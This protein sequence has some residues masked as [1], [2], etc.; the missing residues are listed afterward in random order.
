LILPKLLCASDRE[1]VQRETKFFE[2][3]LIYWEMLM[4]FVTQDAVTFSQ[5]SVTR[6][7]T[8]PSA[9]GAMA[10]NKDGKIVPHPWTGIAP[11]IQL[12]FAEVGRLVRSERLL[13]LN[14]AIDRRRKYDN[15]LNAATLE[16]D[17]LA[18]ECPR[19]DELADPGD[20]YT[21]KRD[22]IVIAEAYRCTGLLEL[23]RVFPSLLRKRLG[24]DRFTWT[25]QVEF[26]FPTP[27][28]ETPYEDTDTKLWLNSLAVHILKTLESLPSSTGTCCLQPI[29]LLA[30]GA[31]LKFVSSV[32]Y[33]DIYANDAKVL[34]ARGFAANRLQE[35]AMR[36][37][38]K[39]VR[40]SIEILNE[41]WR[42]VDDGQ[43]NV[44]WIDVMVEKGWHTIMG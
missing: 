39:P 36:L 15:L 35:Y 40:K 38:A 27:R 23:Y 9:S 43:Q 17:L 26:E 7:R 31:E 24:T 2:D 28:F 14:S 5:G 34:Q 10:R 11:T 42:R 12:L 37:P 20:E 19:A 33:F 6:S 8:T 3:S 1:E 18:A 32:D 4:G 21:A 22:F 13:F 44:F 30:A 29:I 16:E 25:D 41:V